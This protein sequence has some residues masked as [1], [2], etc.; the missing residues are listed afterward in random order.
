MT[1]WKTQLLKWWEAFRARLQR[2]DISARIKIE[3][4]HANQESNHHIN[5]GT[6]TPTG[7]R[8]DRTLFPRF[9]AAASDELLDLIYTDMDKKYSTS[10][11]KDGRWEV[12]TP[13]TLKTFDCLIKAERRCNKL[14]IEN[15]RGRFVYPWRDTGTFKTPKT[16]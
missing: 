9:M 13:R 11:L 8:G 16:I 10:K 5:P 4:I 1:N 2:A 14:R 15:M 12:K 3:E 7:T 6:G